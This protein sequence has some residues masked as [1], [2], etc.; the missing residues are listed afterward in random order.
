MADLTFNTTAGKTINR[1]LLIAY[2]NTG[3]SETPVWSA[4][5]Q[6]VEDSSSEY[7]WDTDTTRDILGNTWGTMKKPVIT[8]EFD[9]VKLDSGNTAYVKLWNIAIKDQDF[10]SLSAQ[11]VL[12][13]HYYTSTSNFAERYPGSMIEIT[14]LGGEG[15]GDI[16]MPFTIT[17]G[18]E[19]VTGTAAKGTGGVVTFTPAA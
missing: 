10:T 16:E 1:E 9:P 12:L 8:Q 13:V 14:G 11:D 5:G 2:L 7:D 3:T 4:L 18:G 19:R 15:G 17:F 6:R